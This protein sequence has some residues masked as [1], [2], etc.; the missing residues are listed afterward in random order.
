[1]PDQAE[2]LA[3]RFGDYL[4][5]RPAGA[6]L[7]LHPDGRTSRVPL[8]GRAFRIL[9]LLVERRGAIVTRQEIMD[10]VWPDV[11]V[12]ENNLSVQ[13]SNLRRALDGNGALGSC[14]QTLPARGYRFLPEATPV[15]RSL[16]D[17]AA[18]PCVAEDRTAAGLNK[19]ARSE[20]GDAA[21]TD[22]ARPQAQRPADAPAITLVSVARRRGAVLIATACFCVAVLF[23]W[24]VGTSP[25]RT[26]PLAATAP[27]AR[28]TSTATP[29]PSPAPGST[30]RPRLSVVVLPFNKFGNGVDDDTADAITEDLTAAITRWHDWQVT[31]R[32]TALTYKGRPIDIRRVGEELG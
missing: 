14:I 9:C 24:F 29:V 17:Q 28:V 19:A 10:A 27:V 8:G 20:V 7:R 5:D 22:P 1:M 18:D 26:I 32:N 12:E 2:P 23:V 6:L 30:A 3:L 21:E 16:P 13:L 25:P 11:V 4:L 15:R 31:A